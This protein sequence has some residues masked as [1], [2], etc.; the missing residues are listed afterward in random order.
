MTS[1]ADAAFGPLLIGTFLKILLFG[2]LIVQGYIYYATYK[3]DKLWMKVFVFILVLIDTVN[4]IFDM[5][6]LYDCL[7]THFADPD[8]ISRATWCESVLACIS[9]SLICVDI[10]RSLLTTL[11]V[12]FATHPAIM[13]ISTSAVQLFYAWRILVL[14]HNHWIVGFVVFSSIVGGLSGISVG[15][16]VRF[17]P[18]YADFQKFEPAVIAWSCALI[19]ADVTIAVTLARWLTTQHKHKSRIPNTTQT[20]DRIIR[21][22]IQTGLLQT[23]LE[24]LHLIFF[25]SDASGTHLIFNYIL[26]KLYSN[27]LLSTLNSRSGWSFGESSDRKDTVPSTVVHVLLKHIHKQ[28]EILQQSDHATEE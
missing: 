11:Y 15:V 27:S 26:S 17:V 7:I 25:V 5:V 9:S 13:A 18:A 24:L 22:T 10:Q 6:Y 16:A 4:V 2:V 1:P 8:Y 21:L 3:K 12:V 28:R 20:V 14:T 19:L 23:A